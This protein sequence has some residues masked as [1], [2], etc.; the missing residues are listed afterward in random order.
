M[1]KQIQ[2]KEFKNHPIPGAGTYCQHYQL[3]FDPFGQANED[4]RYFATPQW[5]EDIDLLQ[6]L[7]HYSNVL[8]A[9]TGERGGG[10]LVANFLS[11]GTLP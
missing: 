5:E 9:V 2:G 10:K 8:I 6:H 1:P 3:R 4:I 11:I 7:T